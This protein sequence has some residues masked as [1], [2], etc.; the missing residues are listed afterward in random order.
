MDLSFIDGTPDTCKCEEYSSTQKMLYPPNYLSGNTP[1][2]HLGN[3]Q[4]SRWIHPYKHSSQFP[5]QDLS[6]LTFLWLPPHSV[7]L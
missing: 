2:L 7:S 4:A 6:A 5:L 1:L 3:C